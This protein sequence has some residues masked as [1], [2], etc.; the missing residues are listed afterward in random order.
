MENRPGG[1]ADPTRRPVRGRRLPPTRPLPHRALHTLGAAYV[2]RCVNSFWFG[3]CAYTFRSHFD[4]G[5]PG[6]AGVPARPSDL[7]D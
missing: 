7:F 1:A 5:G 4:A 3:P 2:G 6:S